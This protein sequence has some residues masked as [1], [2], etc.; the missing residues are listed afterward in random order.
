MTEPN[1]VW[2]SDITYV[3]TAEGVL[4]LSLVTDL[5]S[6]KIVGWAIGPTLERGVSSG[7]LANGDGDTSQRGRADTHPKPLRKPTGKA[8]SRRNVGKVRGI[9][10]K[11]RKKHLYLT[12][13]TKV[14]TVYAYGDRKPGGASSPVGFCQTKSHSG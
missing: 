11:K 12:R 2:V 4:Y 10:R 14:T 9:D 5:Y 1:R 3:E 8:V 6:H 7:S 13:Q